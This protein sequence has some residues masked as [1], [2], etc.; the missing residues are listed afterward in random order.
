MKNI[1]FLIV[2]FLSLYSNLFSN[3]ISV[4]DTSKNQKH[5]HLDSKYFSN[6]Y[7]DPIIM[8]KR[9]LSFDAKDF[10]I[11]GGIAGI[12]TA[13]YFNDANIFEEIQSNRN[14]TYDDISYFLE[15]AGNGIYQI[16]G[17][18][19]TYLYGY[20]TSNNKLAETSLLAIESF[21]ISGIFAQC[22]KISTHRSRPYQGYGEK[23][24]FASNLISRNNVSFPSGHTTSAFSLATVLSM[25]Y[26]KL[27]VSIPAYT[28][29]TLVAISR[30]YDKKHWASDVFAGAVLGHFVAKMVVNINQKSLKIN[31]IFGDGVTGIGFSYNF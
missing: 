29:A 16:S 28:L 23:H 22:I 10:L 31:P 8:G 30:I 4:L 19:A 3:E 18:T 17:L 25:Q 9:F 7:K 11:L 26:N 12:T 24:W 2:L 6:Y 21:A 15:K 14:N 5:L 13:F 1:V 20:Y 27:S